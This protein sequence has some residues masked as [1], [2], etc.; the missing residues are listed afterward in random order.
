MKYL[1]ACFVQHFFNDIYDD[2]EVFTRCIVDTKLGGNT[3][4]MTLTNFE[5]LRAKFQQNSEGAS[6]PKK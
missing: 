4:V 1:Q 5:R 6:Q 2:Q 3:N